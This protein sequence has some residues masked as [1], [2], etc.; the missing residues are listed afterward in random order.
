MS[1]TCVRTVWQAFCLNLGHAPH[2]RNQIIYDLNIERNDA[3]QYGEVENEN[4]S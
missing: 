4:I 1:L 3:K 2:N